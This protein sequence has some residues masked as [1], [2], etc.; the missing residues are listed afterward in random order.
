M[1]HWPA[2]Q[3]LYSDWE[4]INADTWRG[5][6]QLY[7]DGYVKNIGVCNFKEHHLEKLKRS[8]EIMPFMNQIEF[9]PGLYQDSLMEY[10]KRESIIVE[11]SSPLGNGQILQNELLN[12]IAIQKGVSVAQV[13]LRWIIQK[14]IVAIPKTSNKDRLSLNLDIFGFSIEYDEMMEIDNL[15]YCGGIGIDSD[16]VT[17]FG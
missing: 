3:K 4:D 8:A 14:G 5:M 6:E 17:E 13:C 16:E 9:H 11:A 1:I 12:R 7:K 2:S 15:P 10:C